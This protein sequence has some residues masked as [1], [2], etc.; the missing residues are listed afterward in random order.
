MQEWVKSSG[1][2]IIVVFEGQDTAGKGGTIGATS[3]VVSPRVFRVVAL[4]A[5]TDRQKSQMYLPALRRALP[6]RR[7]GHH[8]RPQL[9]QP[10]RR[11]AGNGL[12]PD[13]ARSNA[14]PRAGLVVR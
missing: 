5:P 1:A 6:R 9:V 8:L 11:R 12:H 3:P 2:K 13:E 4:P 7:R 10:G 14:V